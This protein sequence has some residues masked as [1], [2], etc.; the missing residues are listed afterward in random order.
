MVV[1]PV[2]AVSLLLLLVSST[3]AVYCQLL[4]LQ[5]DVQDGKDRVAQQLTSY[6]V[7]TTQ[8]NYRKSTSLPRVVPFFGQQPD[9]W[10]AGL[11]KVDASCSSLRNN[12]NLLTGHVCLLMTVSSGMRFV[13]RSRV[14]KVVNV[15]AGKI[16]QETNQWVPGS[17]ASLHV[18]C[19]AGNK[20]S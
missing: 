4:L 15:A 5:A 3:T 20:T 6:Q 7:A 11:A 8:G 17:E 10:P 19:G 16:V 9:A 18:A 1:R 13:L 14:S 2:E 12:R